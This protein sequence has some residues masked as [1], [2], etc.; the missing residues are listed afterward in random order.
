V[1]PIGTVPQFHAEVKNFF[2]LR[3]FFF[4]KVPL[5]AVQTVPNSGGFLLLSHSV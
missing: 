1:L 3:L 2:F 4:P 5:T